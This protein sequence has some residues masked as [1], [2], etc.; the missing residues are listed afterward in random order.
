MVFALIAQPFYGVV[1]G[2]IANAEEVT[3]TNTELLTEPAKETETTEVIKTE[4]PALPVSENVIAE[5]SEG[6][7]GSFIASMLSRSIKVAR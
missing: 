1:A 3:T 4:E 6:K 2:S 5:N 7:A